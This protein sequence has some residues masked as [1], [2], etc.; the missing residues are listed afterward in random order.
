MRSIQVVS[1][2]HPGYTVVKVPRDDR[3]E[4]RALPGRHFPVDI[5]VQGIPDL[6]QALDLD[7]RE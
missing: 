6:F 4:S 5:G 1:L 7:R 2:R 3:D